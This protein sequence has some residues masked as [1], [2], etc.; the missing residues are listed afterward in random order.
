MKL[1]S[2]VM[3]DL[4]G[5]LLDSNNQI[6]PNTKRLLN[7]LQ[8]RGVPVVLCSSGPP[9][10]AIA[11]AR[12]C[13]L[14]GLLVCYDGS[15]ILDQNQNILAD[16]GI[17]GETALRLKQAAAIEFPDIAVTSC[18]YDIW[19]ADSAQDPNVLA[20]GKRYGREAIE[21]PLRNALQSNGHAH[22]MICLGQPLRLKTFQNWAA[23]LFPSLSVNAF[24]ATCLDI[25]AAGVSKGAAMK[26][27]Q[28]YYNVT[29][30]QIVAAGDYFTDM[31]MLRRAGLGIAMGN[32]PEAV[33]RAAARVTAS[34][35][36]EGVYIALKNL[37]FRPPTEKEIPPE[38]Q[39]D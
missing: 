31:E 22:K 2:L 37:R 29:A 9:S 25:T 27:I 5:T 19:L 35:D 4:G 7:R 23:P 14:T 38:I 24:G 11:A 33:K 18:L 10:G 32:A 16:T 3:L 21:G 15:L 1:Y 8:Q 30:E 17:D 28:S 34:N 20:F 13:G 36:E 6:S 39:T 26:K 12:L